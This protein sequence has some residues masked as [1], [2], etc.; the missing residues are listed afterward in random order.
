MAAREAVVLGGGKYFDV[1]TGRRDGFYSIASEALNLLP[2]AEISVDDSIALF[3]SLGFD[4]PEMVTLI[5]SHTIGFTH[6]SAFKDRLYNYENTGKADPTMDEVLLHILKVICP[7][8]S[9]TDNIVNLDQNP[10]SVITVDNSFFKE[11]QESK[12]ILEIDQHIDLD[13]RTN[14]TVK[15]LANDNT[16]FNEQFAAALVK[17]GAVNVLLEP[18][19]EIR[20]SCRSSNFPPLP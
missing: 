10:F 15:M 4:I 2:P 1:M 6:C 20:T 16:L 11:I 13:I 14:A 5:G 8:S 3:A 19:G 12:G 17:L 7:M 9:R 18:L